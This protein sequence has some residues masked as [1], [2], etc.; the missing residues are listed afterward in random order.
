MA[1]QVSQPAALALEYTARDVADLQEMRSKAEADLAAARSA[2]D[3][4]HRA[5]GES[6]HSDDGS[7]GDVIAKILKEIHEIAAHRDA[8]LAERDAARKALAEAE[9][10]AAPGA[11]PA[12]LPTIQEKQS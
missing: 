3:S 11:S 7:L 9:A 6:E 1:D 5:L 12:A 2:L 8:A 10:R 4:V